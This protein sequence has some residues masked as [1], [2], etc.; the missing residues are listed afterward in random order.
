MGRR[1]MLRESQSRVAVCVAVLV[2]A[3]LGSTASAQERWSRGQNIQPVFEGWARAAAAQ[4][5]GRTVLALEALDRLGEAQEIDAADRESAV[6][7]L[8]RVVSESDAD[9]IAEAYDALP[10]DGSAWPEVAMRAI[11][12]AFDAGDM[13]RVSAIVAELRQRRA[14]RPEGDR[15][16]RA[17]HRPRARGGAAHR[18]WPHARLRLS[19]AGAARSRRAAAR[20]ARRRR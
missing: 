5:E 8:R 10:R 19:D 7:D 16:H 14:R 13:A 18:A 6:E 17:A 15:R 3:L 12:L 1:L 20:V 9:A 11:R 4:R 2:A